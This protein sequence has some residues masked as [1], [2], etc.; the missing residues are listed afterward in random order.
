MKL[1]LIFS[2]LLIVL[3]RAFCTF[4][5]IPIAERL[6]DSSFLLVTAGNDRHMAALPI[7]ASVALISVSLLM[8]SSVKKA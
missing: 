8:G 3:G 1:L 7:I 2:I 4:Y 5:S 6:V